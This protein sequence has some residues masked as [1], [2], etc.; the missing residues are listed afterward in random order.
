MTMRKALEKGTALLKKKGIPMPFLD[1]QILLAF[2]LGVS[3]EVLL[4][5]DDRV[6]TLEELDAFDAALA[7]RQDFEPIAKI[8]HQKDFWKST[9]YTSRETLDPRP[10]SETLIE[11]V[12][13]AFPE[14]QAPLK[15]L[16]LGIGTGCLLFSLLQEYPKAWGLGIDKSV[17]ALKNA[18][19]NQKKLDLEQRSAL[20]AGDWGDALLACPE[21]RFD[22]VVCNP[23]YIAEHEEESLSLDLKFEPRGA[24]FAGVDGLEAYQRLCQSVYFLLKPEGLLF[25]EIGKNQE[26]QI[27]T[28]CQLVDLRLRNYKKDLAGITRCAIFA[29]MPQKK[30]LAF[31]NALVKFI[32]SLVIKLPGY[33]KS[34]TETHKKYEKKYLDKTYET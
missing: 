23:P 21:G 34:F 29:W 2:I 16:D 9:F 27:L 33:R 19:Y 28:I 4:L 18:S 8:T 6:L 30:R 31:V 25:L 12:L 32:L 22:V 5:S 1:A 17:E 15:I 20:M 3:R 14:R 26:V 10:D 11:A 24:L 13:D 7:R